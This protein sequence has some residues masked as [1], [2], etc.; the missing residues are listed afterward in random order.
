M[1]HDHINLGGSGS[2]LTEEAI[3]QRDVP[4]AHIEKSGGLAEFLKKFPRC[5]VYAGQDIGASGGPAIP[6][7]KKPKKQLCCTAPN[8]LE[9]KQKQ[10]PKPKKCGDC[11]QKLPLYGLPEDGVRRW[12]TKFRLPYAHCSNLTNR[13]L[14]P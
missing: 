8:N 13:E 12:C 7:P 5:E 2:A 9:P 11:K 10:T 4:W 14:L 1:H 6:K 3:R